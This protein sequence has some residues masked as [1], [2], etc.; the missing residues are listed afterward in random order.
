MAKP[1]PSDVWFGH[2]SDIEIAAAAKQFQQDA[3]ALQRKAAEAQAHAARL[4]RELRRRKRAAKA[5]G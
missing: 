4:R 3:A 5:G 2:M 1:A